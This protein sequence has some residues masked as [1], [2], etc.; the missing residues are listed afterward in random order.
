M[1]TVLI[2]FHVLAAVG[3]IGGM[4]F[5]SL[6]LAPVFRS[7]RSNP[8][9]GP[10]FMTAAKRFR[11][12]VWSAVAILLGTGPVLLHQRGLSFLDPS[13]WPRVLTVKL[14]LV[15][16]LVL[17][18]ALHDL[19]LGPRTA[20]ASG[21]APRARSRMEDLLLTTSAWLPRLSLLLAVM[22]LFAAVVLART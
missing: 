11:F 1:T 9:I 22:V 2:W 10:F 16:A 13:S 12:V 6:V 21:T 14:A 5:L 20:A 8:E 7:H 19:I 15:A 3:W 4:L 17:L 18:T